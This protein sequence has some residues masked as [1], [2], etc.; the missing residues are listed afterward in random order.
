MEALK[1]K[2]HSLLAVKIIAALIIILL[3]LT[4]PASAT[5]QQEIDDVGKQIDAKKAEQSQTQAQID[6]LTKQLEEITAQYQSA[7]AELSKTEEEIS[8]SQRQLNSAIEQQKYYQ[9]TLNQR[10]VFAYRYGKV[11]FLEVLMDTKNFQDFLVRLDFLAK[12]SER[13]AQVLKASKKLKTEIE[14]RRNEL[15]EQKNRQRELVNILANKE[16]EMSKTLASQ[17]ELLNSLQGE[18]QTLAV[19]QQKLIEAKK[20]EEERLAQ[21]AAAGNRDGKNISDNAGGGAN[22]SSKPLNIVFPVPR[23]YAHSYTNDWGNPRPGGTYH[24]GTDIFGAR[25]TPLVA[26]A[27]GVISSSFGQQRLG[28][29]RLWVDGDDGYS[30]YY[31]HLNGDEGVAYAPGIAPG[32]RVT[33]GQIIAYM[34]DSGQAKGTGVHLHFGITWNDQ[35]IN[36]YPYIKAV[37][38]LR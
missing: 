26:A 24:Q 11:Y 25:G 34:G 9:K 22:P 5:L 38:W 19:D 36:P 7:Y 35:W 4:G 10:S 30:Y 37:D 17:Q 1:I 33:Q 8:K 28:G 29:Y 15:E 32:V 16:D 12:V 23:P 13:D 27:D 6:A 14:A 21:L 3:A 18:I 31:A 2:I 20:A